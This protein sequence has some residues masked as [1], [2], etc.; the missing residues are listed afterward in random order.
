[1]KSSIYDSF[2]AMIETLPARAIIRALDRQRCM[3]E[4]DLALQ[5]PVPLKD[6]ESIL[7]FCHFVEAVREGLPGWAFTSPPSPR[8]LEFYRKTLERL[9]ASEELPYDARTEFD[10][11]IADC[12]L[13]PLHYAS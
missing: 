7:N 4:E 11:I 1:M 6:A 8:H 3:L 9:V 2:A 13:R 10:G 12:C 5:R